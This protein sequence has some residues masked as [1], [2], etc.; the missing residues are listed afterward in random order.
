MKAKL[1]STGQPVIIVES[2]DDGKFKV[3]FEDKPSISK[4]VKANELANG[5]FFKW[6]VIKWIIKMKKRYGN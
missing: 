3:T 2:F 6:I 1:K 4:Y 5:W